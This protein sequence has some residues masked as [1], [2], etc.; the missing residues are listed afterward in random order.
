MSFYFSSTKSQNKSVEQVLSE[1]DGTSGREEDVEKECRRVNI[2]QTLVCIYVN[3]ER[4]LLKLLQ[5]WEKENRKE[6]DG[7]VNSTMI[8]LIYCKNFCKCHNVFPPTKTI[9]KENRVREA[10][11]SSIFEN[12]TG[13]YFEPVLKGNYLKPS[14]GG[15][16]LGCA[17]QG[18][19]YEN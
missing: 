14:L 2:V 10:V 6:S 17:L 19:S 9:K 8:Y 3:G 5:E 16:L 13:N 1:G 4:Y 12:L 7:G 15:K 11:R 18:G